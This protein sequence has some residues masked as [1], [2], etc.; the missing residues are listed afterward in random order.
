MNT[1]NSLVQD[2]NL[3]SMVFGRIAGWG[4]SFSGTIPR[5]TSLCIQMCL[6]ADESLGID[7]SKC[8]K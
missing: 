1:D 7:F 4:H 3:E 6:K 8:M 2:K 5:K